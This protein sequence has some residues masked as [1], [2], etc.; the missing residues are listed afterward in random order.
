MT[1]IIDGVITAGTSASGRGTVRFERTYA[2]PPGAVWS[3][4]TNPDRIARWL[5]A[6]SGDLQPG[7]EFRLD[8]GDGDVALGRVLICEETSRLA[9][10]WEFE[11]EGT[12]R[13]EITLTPR[14]DGTLVTLHHSE[15]RQAD[16]SQ[17]GAGWHTF[18][19]HLEIVL[20]GNIPTAWYERFEDLLPGY[21]AQLDR[22]PA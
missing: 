7:G 3:A 2:Y 20:A 16:L 18:L 8:F 6:V 10:S 13:L 21:Q 12:T 15:L 4:I 1:D 5:A 22:D 11:S 19:E 17:Y 14:D 9:V